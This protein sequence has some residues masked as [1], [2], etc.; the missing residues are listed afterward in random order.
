MKE[1][2]LILQD[3]G[4]IIQPFW[5]SLFCHMQPEVQN[6]AMHQTYQTDLTKVWLE[7]A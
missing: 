4:I 1:I 7:T 3:S 5:Q 2:Q 6:H